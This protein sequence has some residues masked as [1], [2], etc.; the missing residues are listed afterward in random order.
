MQN[1]EQ[2]KIKT[3]K[4]SKDKQKDN[5]NKQNHHQQGKHAHEA[6]FWDTFSSLFFPPLF[7]KLLFNLWFDNNLSLFVRKLK[8]PNA[9]RVLDVFLEVLSQHFQFLTAWFFDWI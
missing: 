7:Y 8:E 4:K 5:Q 6:A 1:K 3:N 9:N 2:F